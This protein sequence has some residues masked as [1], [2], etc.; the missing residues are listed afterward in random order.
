VV[1]KIKE[2]SND[3]QTSKHINDIEAQIEMKNLN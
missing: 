2:P 1:K 3:N